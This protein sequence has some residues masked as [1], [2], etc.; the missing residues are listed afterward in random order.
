MPVW[1]I[2]RDRSSKHRPLAYGQ[3]KKMVNHHLAL[4]VFKYNFV[5]VF[6]IVLWF[7]FLNIE[8]A[9]ANCAADVGERDPTCVRMALFSDTQI[10]GVIHEGAPYPLKHITL[11]D[12]DRYI[13]RII[14]SV[15]QNYDPDVVAILG[16][17]LD[18]GV[19]A[20]DEQYKGYVERFD[21]YIRKPIYSFYEER[22]EDGDLFLLA[23]DND[24]GGEGRD[25][26][27]DA[28]TDR[29]VKNFGLLNHSIEVKGVIIAQI[30]TVSL[31]T[32]RRLMK[33]TWAPAEANDAID[34]F[35]EKNIRNS[36][37]LTHYPLS[38]MTKKLQA[39][40]E[41]E[42]QPAHIFSGD[43]HYPGHFKHSFV[44][45]DTVPATSYR[46]ETN[47]M[48]FGIADI[49][50]LDDEVKVS[51]S[52]CVTPPRYLPDFALYV[53]FVL[54]EALLGIY[55]AVRWIVRPRSD[56]VYQSVLEQPPK[57]AH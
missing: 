8:F 24:I 48:G 39:V 16:D 44:E 17:L 29:H 54:P 18:E 4:A 5:I 21:R 36:I 26:L 49:C 22:D 56:L 12:A 31:S 6:I 46:M 20:S 28:S 25:L 35:K 11:W 47:E 51:Y 9:V 14:I 53:I 10:P 55:L 34:E 42:M 37:L 41:H 2:D 43:T 15:L 27:T 19:E 38:K 23:G 30:D 40:I 33:A 57:K 32:P 50:A 1:D 3:S 45:E 13:S 52:R 7:Q